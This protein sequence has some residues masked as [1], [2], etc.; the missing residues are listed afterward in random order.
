MNIPQKVVLGLWALTVATTLY[1]PPTYYSMKVSHI[2][3]GRLALFILAQT[4]VAGVLIVVL[5]SKQ[6]SD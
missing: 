4:I 5:K 6:K 1:E 2:E 3:Y